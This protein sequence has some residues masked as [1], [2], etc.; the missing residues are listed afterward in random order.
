MKDSEFLRTDKVPMTKQ[1][2]RAVV[3]DRLEL[4]EARRFVDIGAGTGSVAIEVALRVPQLEVTAVERKA[5]AVDI[6][7][8]NM[9]QLKCQQIK[10]IRDEAPCELEG[11]LDAVFIGGTG[12]NLEEIIQWALEKMVVGGRLVMTF[13]LHDNLNQAL[14][15]LKSCPVEQLDCVQILASS[16]TSLGNSYYFKPNNPTFIVSCIKGN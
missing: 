3:L 14:T 8:E 9:Q 13:I 7:L 6:M 2:V 1:E 12:G 5:E 16:M 4:K 15:C 11:E 10:L